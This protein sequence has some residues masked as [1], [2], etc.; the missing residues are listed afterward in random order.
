MRLIIGIVVFIPFAV[1][2]GVFAVENRQ[3]LT[4][5]FWPLANKIETSASVWLLLFLGIGIL[6]GLGIGWLSTMAWRRRA[7]KAERINRTLERKLDE[8][9]ISTAAQLPARFW[10][11]VT[12]AVVVAGPRPRQ[13][14]NDRQLIGFQSG[15]ATMPRAL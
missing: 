4:L 11:G 12:G 1:L 8:R 5:E 15:D 9:V 10:R 13:D 3:M 6:V 2:L 14:H 7:W